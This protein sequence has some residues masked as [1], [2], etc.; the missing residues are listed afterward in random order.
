[1]FAKDHPA[2]HARDD[3]PGRQPR[4]DRSAGL[5]IEARQAAALYP[6]RVP[7][8]WAGRMAW[9]DPRDPLQRQVMPSGEELRP[10][11]GFVTDPLAEQA[12]RTL[13]GLLQKYAGRVLLQ[14]SGACPIHCRF[15]FRRH[16]GYAN[17]PDSQSAWSPVVAAIANDP[18]LREVV[19]SGGDPLMQSDR[20]LMALVRR[21][22][23]I[24]HLQRLRVHSRMPVVTPRRVGPRLLQWLTATRLTPV[25]VI[26]C[27]HPAELDATVLAGLTRLQQAGVLVLN[28]SVL[29]RGVNDDP[30]ILADLCET[31]VNHRVLP[32][33]L[34]L[35]DPVAGSAHFQV[36]REQAR[37]LISQLQARLP[38]YAVPK[39]VW[40]QPGQP[41]KMPVELCMP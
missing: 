8:A 35:L 38:G 18:S 21:L 41:S 25:L 26:H 14:V 19:L 12:G 13:P 33:Y 24:P 3:L 6:L 22:A 1:M 15:C 30:A 31:L 40:E 2:A 37:S 32:Y 4:P 9:H 29:L 39:L 7:S 23:D 5:D 27:N 36:D 11:V 17:L 28:Q 10:A 34:H 20:F 16:D